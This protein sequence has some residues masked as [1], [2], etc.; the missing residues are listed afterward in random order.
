MAEGRSDEPVSSEHDQGIKL[1]F[2][3]SFLFIS[4]IIIGVTLDPF[5]FPDIGIWPL[6]GVAAVTSAFSALGTLALA[7]VTY[8]TLEQNSNLIDLQRE[9]VKELKRDRELT[10]KKV[11]QDKKRIIIKIVS[12]GLYKMDENL[13]NMESSLSDIDPESKSIPSMSYLKIDDHILKDL[14]DK[15]PELIKKYR[16]FEN[17]LENYSQKRRKMDNMLEGYFPNFRPEN[18]EERISKLAEEDDRIY[19]QPSRNIRENSSFLIECVFIGDIP[20]SSGDYQA[21][22][23]DEF[24]QEVDNVRQEPEFKSRVSELIKLRNQLRNSLDELIHYPEPAIQSY[25]DEYPIT[26]TEIKEYRD[27]QS[28]IGFR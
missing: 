20:S 8:T 16:E 19:S 5:I 2:G 1:L 11:K 17:T 6:N 12:E 24:K 23:Y 21:L 27:E 14:E 3:F 15:N 10:E 18:F 26:I 28:S 7:Y 22:L 4:F 9:Q 25:L 13:K